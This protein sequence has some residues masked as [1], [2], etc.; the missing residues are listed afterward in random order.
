MSAHE[1]TPLAKQTTAQTILLVE[2]EA[3]IALSEKVMLQKHGFTVLTAANGI[4]AV[5]IALHTPQIDLI[6]MDINLGSGMDGTEAAQQ[7]LAQRDVPIV[8]LSSH[9][10][11]DVVAK[12]EKIT[13]YGYVVK[14]SGETVLVASIKMAFKL[15]DA[16]QRLK[17]QEAA[18]RKTKQELQIIF[19]T[20]PALIW[21]K[22]CTGTYVQVNKAYCDT[23][24]LSEE[25]ILGK[26]D[27]ELYPPE[28]AD[29]YVSTDQKV[30]N[31]GVPAFGTEQRYQR[32]SGE[33]GWNQTDK[34][35]YYD[36]TGN[37]AGTIGFAL[38]ITERKRAEEAL[39]E[40]EARFRRLAENSQD[41]IYRMSLPDGRYEYINPA[42]TELTGY[43]PEEWYASPKLVQKIIHPDWQGYFETQ[44]AELL[45]GNM[46]PTYKFQL[47]HKSGKV[48]WLHQRNV[49]IRN[50]AGCPIAIEG[51]VIDITNRKL[52]EEE[53]NITLK[54]YQ[55]LFDSFPMG[56]SITDRHGKIIETNHEAER[57]LGISREKHT[58][59]TYDD[60]RWRVI[61]PDGT[62]M[63]AEEYASVRAMHEQRL[64]ENVEMGIVK[65]QNNIIWI[66]VTAAPI[67][68][69]NYGV[70]IAYGDITD[71]KRAEETLRE[72]EERF[73]LFMQHLPGLAFIKD[74]NGRL[75]FV[76]A[77]HAN[78]YPLDPKEMIGQNLK[79]FWS[80]EYIAQFTEQ[81]RIILDS[82]QPLTSE[83][84]YPDHEGSKWWLTCKFPIFQRGKPTL[85]GGIS[86][87]ITARK[88]AEEAL[89][90][91][92]QQFRELNAQKDKFFSILA[93]DLKNPIV[94]FISFANLLEDNFTSMDSEER[95]LLI[96]YFRMSAKTLFTLLENLLTWARLQQGEVECHFDQ[97]PIDQL[98]ARA[99]ALLTPNAM[100]KHITLTN[101]TPL[102]NVYASIEM[103]DAVVRNLLAN[104]IKFTPSG[105]AVTIT[106]TETATDVCVTVAD[107]GIG[108]P[109]DKLAQLFRIDGKT[110]RDGTSGEKG[111]G[112]GLILCKE[113]VEK[114]GGQIWAESEPGNGTR[115]MFTLP[116]QP[117]ER[118]H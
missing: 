4:E 105:G 10:E 54:K 16:Y 75:L 84:S 58:Q 86:L 111:T 34:L 67:P 63:P 110:Q 37:I 66:S 71:R 26:T 35:P 20:V 74:T 89:Q 17:Q 7:I 102:I 77:Y 61:R 15:F 40:S 60:P 96:Q 50:E 117:S 30:L 3:L 72:S 79:N 21:Q 32:L 115:V 73:N 82:R 92:E 6:L 11:S 94:G 64:I 57:L 46:S 68:L 114:Q 103:V 107:T 9:T 48:K 24:G 2:D 22:D 19:D 18:L 59:R 36:S 45:A 113:F 13:S 98:V 12:T 38:D 27:E 101:T 90:K 41:M 28:I 29:Q 91:S 51:I 69:E 62:P 99:V 100:Y 39:R 14:N 47:I 76:N 83:E 106:A 104:A 109:P 118:E 44:W 87:D 65:E 55:A 88:R 56:I 42:C 97:F 49:L 80:P 33:C 116:T 53:L 95:Q 93:H 81:D 108:I 78:L 70:A 43:T 25:D 1:A 112:L 85:I 5:E 31:S 52:V 23:I 8:F